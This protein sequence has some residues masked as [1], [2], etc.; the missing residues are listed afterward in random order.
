MTIDEAAALAAV[1]LNSTF[2]LPRNS[3]FCGEIPRLGST[4][5]GISITMHVGTLVRY[6]TR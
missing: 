5:T 1:G 6:H 2:S 3:P 4:G